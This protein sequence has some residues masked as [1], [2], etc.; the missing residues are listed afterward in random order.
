MM[1]ILL[2]VM[3]VILTVKLKKAGSVT[4]VMNKM[5]M[6]VTIKDLLLI[7]SIVK[8]LINKF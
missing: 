4:E 3:D 5:L 7:K 2:M 6:F 1:V 8:L